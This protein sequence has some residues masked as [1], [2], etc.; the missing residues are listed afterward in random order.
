[1]TAQIVAALM[2]CDNECSFVVQH[3]VSVVTQA[4]L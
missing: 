4:T 1:M 3:L 2:S